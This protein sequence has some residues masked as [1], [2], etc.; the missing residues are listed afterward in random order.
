MKPS[1]VPTKHDLNMG[2]RWPGSKKVACVGCER[3]LHPVSKGGRQ[4]LA[5]N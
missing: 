3:Q 5:L 2:L 4:A 1:T